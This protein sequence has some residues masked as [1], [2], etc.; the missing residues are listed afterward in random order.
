MIAFQPGVPAF[1]NNFQRPAY[2]RIMSR[3]N[4][5]KNS[6]MFTMLI[7]IKFMLEDSN[8]KCLFDVQE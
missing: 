6:A 3:I 2:G 7:F 8:H 1:S 4:A 5:I